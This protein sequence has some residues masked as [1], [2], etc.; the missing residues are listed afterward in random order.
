MP[1]ACKAR[2][3]VRVI[4]I[5]IA[6]SALS[7]AIH[8][9]GHYHG[10]NESAEGDITM[11]AAVRAAIYLRVSTGRQADNDLSIPDRRQAKAYCASRGWEI[12]AD[13]VEPGAPGHARRKR[14]GSATRR[15]SL[16]ATGHCNFTSQCNFN[17]GQGFSTNITP[18]SAPWRAHGRLTDRAMMKQCR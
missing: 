3:P 14:G 4:R 16:A 11:A 10:G 5:D 9:S 12:A 1:D 2:L 7:S 6:M 13:Y 17:R 8:H 15:R 18:N